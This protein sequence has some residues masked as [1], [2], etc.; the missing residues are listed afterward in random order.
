MGTTTRRTTRLQSNVHVRVRRAE[1][2]RAGVKRSSSSSYSSRS[3]S[4]ATQRAMGQQGGEGEEKTGVMRGGGEPDPSFSE[5]PLS[6]FEPES[7]P[8]RTMPFLNIS[9]LPDKQSVGAAVGLA[10]VGCG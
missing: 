8:V 2:R 7:D 3:S 4:S 1:T 6:G 9:K 10:A 5:V